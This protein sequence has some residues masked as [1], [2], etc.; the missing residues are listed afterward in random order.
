[1]A[2]PPR[3]AMVRAATADDALAIATVQA[4]TWRATY[5]GLLDDDALDALD[6]VANSERYR[7]H[8]ELPL[9]ERHVETLVATVSG[10]V[11]GYVAY[12]PQRTPADA[13]DGGLG[14]LHALYVLP[15][16]QGRGLGTALLSAACAGLR[17][18]GCARAVL[19]VLTG[20]AATRAFYERHG[21]VRDGAGRVEVVMGARVDEVPYARELSD[22]G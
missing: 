1:M 18:R 21:W 15:E 20:N 22:D 12:G 13:V 4:S 2:G 19:W 10:A 3:H 8:L 6:P 16:H 9:P 7:A 17:R 11:V 5:R 14:E